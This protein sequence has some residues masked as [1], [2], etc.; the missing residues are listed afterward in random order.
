MYSFYFESQEVKTN[1]RDF[2]KKLDKFNPEFV[3]K[4]TYHPQSLF[5][6]RP[7]TRQSSSIPGHTESVLSSQFSPDS[8]NMAS[9]SGDTTVRFWDVDTELPKAKSAGGHKNW[10]LCI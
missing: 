9:G 10:V 3:L 1:L 2:T 7:I 6:V 8:L 4:L 5:F